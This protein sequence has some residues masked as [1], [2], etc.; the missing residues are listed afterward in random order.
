[1]KK[2]TSKFPGLKVLIVEDYF[3]NQ[4]VTKDILEL[5]QC[6]V[7]AVDNGTE[8]IELCKENFYDII[9]MDVQ[10]P[11]MDGL[12]ITKHIRAIKYPD[13]RK[14]VI[15][16]LTASVLNNAKERCLEAGMEDFIAKPMEAEKIEDILRK[17]FA[18]SVKNA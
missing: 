4:E 9:F 12:E 7:E 15:V 1:M 17:Y 14:P 18:S 3:I 13:G 16:A 6:D 11:D 10:M 2:I 5:M 8:A